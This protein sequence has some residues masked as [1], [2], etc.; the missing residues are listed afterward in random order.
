VRE[1]VPFADLDRNMHGDI[2]YIAE[3]VRDGRIVDAV[4]SQIGP[5]LF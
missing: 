1:R 4:E 5:L 2:E 3:L